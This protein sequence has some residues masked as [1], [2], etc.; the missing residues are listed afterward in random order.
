M[1][2]GL[3]SFLSG[4]RTKLRGQYSCHRI[5]PAVSGQRLQI[6]ST[7]DN[8]GFYLLVSDIKTIAPYSTDKY[9]SYQRFGRCVMVSLSVSKAYKT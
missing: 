1:R 8:I 4:H 2:P 9:R 5:F 7:T 3:A 6:S